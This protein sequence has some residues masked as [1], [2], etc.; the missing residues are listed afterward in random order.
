MAMLDNCRKADI[1]DEEGNLLCQAAVRTGPTGGV[2]V[3]VPR[4][5]DYKAQEFFQIL[6]YDPV[7]GMLTCRCA[8]SAPLD[9]PDRMRSLRCEVVERLNQENRRQ[10]VKVSVGVEV[11]IHVSRQP[12]DTVQVPE[13][14]VPATVLNISA[15]GVYLRTALPLKEGRRLWFDFNEAGD[16]IPLKAQILRVDDATIYPSQPLYGYGCQFVGLS[17]RHE[18]QLRSFVFREEMRKRQR[19]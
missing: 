9:M 16:T 13:S 3:V 11:M 19:D 12:G 2:L 5:M 7:L 6:F 14:G 1:F 15:G 8:L 17:T 18:S 10:D 4:E